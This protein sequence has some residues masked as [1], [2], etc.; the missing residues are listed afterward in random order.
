MV[1]S[2]LDVELTKITA[3]HSFILL[4]IYHPPPIFPLPR[5]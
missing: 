4:Q 3:I 1:L 5:S 2:N